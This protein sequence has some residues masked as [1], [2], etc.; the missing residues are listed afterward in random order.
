[1]T[2]SYP[3]KADTVYLLLKAIDEDPVVI[4]DG[5]DPD[6]SDFLSSNHHCFAY[7]VIIHLGLLEKDPLKRISP[8]EALNHRW[9]NSDRAS[10]KQ[11]RSTLWKQIRT[12]I[13]R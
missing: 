6:F 8:V 4:P 11:K 13:F 5:L 7:W 3:Y 10:V 2:G 12:S 1:M 9:V